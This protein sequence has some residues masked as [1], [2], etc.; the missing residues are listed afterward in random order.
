MS[1]ERTREVD[2]PFSDS[3]DDDHPL[4]GSAEPVPHVPGSRTRSQ[5][6]EKPPRKRRHRIAPVI[7]FLVIL[8][9]VGASYVLVRSIRAD[10][11]TPDYTGSGQGSTRVKVSPGDGANDIAASMLKAGVVKSSRAFVNAAKKSGRSGD[12]QPGT[13]K[14]PLRAS[15]SAAVAAVLDPA[16]KLVSQVTIPEGLSQTQVLAQLASKTGVPMAKLT[17]AAK[18]VANLGLPAAYRPPSAEGFLYPAT[19]DID[20]GTSAEAV[21]QTLTAQFGAE[22]QRLG[23]QAAAKAIGITPYQAVIIASIVEGEAK[24]DADRAKVTRVILNRIAKH[25]PLQIDATSVYAARIAGLDP[26][27]VDFATIK[28]PYNGY[29]HAGLPPTP[30]NSPGETSLRAA[31][32]PAAGSWLYYVNGDAAGH[33]SFFTDEASFL[34]AVNVCRA[35]G[36]GCA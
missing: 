33:L 19:Y 29:T 4:F 5:R 34:A 7:A 11:V 17:A 26:A 2:G 13:Y 24:F 23:L 3:P 15:G 21:I 6:R 30:I 25:R 12:I 27:K 31:V 35:K 18:Q 20:P 9:V 32:H 16:N 10:L 14:V 8:V 1:Q 22:D 36:W 28:S